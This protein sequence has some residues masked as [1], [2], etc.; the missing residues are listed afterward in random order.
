MS[1]KEL[2]S[3]KLD[4][5]AR[6][7]QKS[8]SKT[9]DF[10]S[11]K[12]TNVPEKSPEKYP[13]FSKSKTS[14]SS[15]KRL[16]AFALNSPSK[17]NTSKDNE[18]SS[19]SSSSNAYK[20]T[21]PRSSSPPRSLSKS[22]MRNPSSIPMRTPSPPHRFSKNSMKDDDISDD[23][24]S[25]DSEL[26]RIIQESINSARSKEKFISPKIS[27]SKFSSPR[28]DN[29][30]NSDDEL[31]NAIQESLSYSK[32]RDDKQEYE[33]LSEELTFLR[34]EQAEI[35]ESI[36]SEYKSLEKRIEETDEHYQKW[37]NSLKE[38]EKALAEE[39]RVFEEEK[40]NS[41]RKTV[42]NVENTKDF[43]KSKAKIVNVKFP[44]KIIKD[45]ELIRTLIVNKS[46]DELL[47]DILSEITDAADLS[48]DAVFIVDGTQR[49]SINKHSNTSIGDLNINRKTLELIVK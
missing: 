9:M 34:R 29:S 24:I 6:L 28:N 3:D 22:S 8:K 16:D 48:I 17:S 38:R 15:Y 7:R 37:E 47:S 10:S 26:Q 40:L 20:F 36:A 25:S 43:S 35:K 14:N 11:K 41:I 18:S 45:G 31:N 30:D 39:R 4:Q 44:I 21:P 19:S 2:T 1:D 42:G 23:D 46:S 33:R 12:S 32:I 27:P 13:S 5:L 49:I